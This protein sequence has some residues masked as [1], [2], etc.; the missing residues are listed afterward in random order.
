MMLAH[1]DYRSALANLA[2]PAFPVPTAA[3]KLALLF[4][5]EQNQWRTQE[6]IEASQFEQIRQ[7]LCCF[8]G[9]L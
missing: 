3:T 2:W 7:M 5:I 1:W 4:Q 8:P 6:A 9:L